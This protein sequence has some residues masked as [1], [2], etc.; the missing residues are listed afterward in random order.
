M[1][2]LYICVWVYVC[3]YREGEGESKP[4]M[5]A[6]KSFTKI[7]RQRDPFSKVMYFTLKKSN[8]QPHMH[9]FGHQNSSVTLGQ[10]S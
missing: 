7:T 5:K 3:V 4:Y 6:S 1:K 10:V 9:Y 8:I 2:L